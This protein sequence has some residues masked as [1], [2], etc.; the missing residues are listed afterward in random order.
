[1]SASSSK[2]QGLRHGPLSPQ[3]VH[4]CVDMQR[5][6]AEDTEWKTPWMERVLPNVV[7]LVEAHPDTNHLH[8]LHPGRASWRGRRRVAPLLAPLGQT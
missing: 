7:R 4:V 1:M 6:F 3:T 8:P 2:P 5:L